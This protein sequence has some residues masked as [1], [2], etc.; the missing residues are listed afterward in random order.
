MKP[1]NRQVY[2][3]PSYYVKMTYQWYRCQYT[4]KHLCNEFMGTTRS[5]PFH[6]QMCDNHPK[7]H[8]CVII[9]VLEAFLRTFS[10]YLLIHKSVVAPPRELFPNW[11]KVSLRTTHDW[12]IKFKRGNEKHYSEQVLHFPFIYWQHVGMLH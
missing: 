7:P 6:A 1:K 9:F 12:R 5:L 11:T 2:G 3:Q 8:K 10:S 4:L